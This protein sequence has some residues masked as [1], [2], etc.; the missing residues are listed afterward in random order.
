M[1]MWDYDERNVKITMYRFSVDITVAIH[2]IRN[3]PRAIMIG[4]PLTTCC[5]V[6]VNVAYLA[7]LSPAEMMA[8]EAVAVVSACP[9]RMQFVVRF[10]FAIGT[11]PIT[12]ASGL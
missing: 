3:L 7:V 6:L 5:Y 2:V 4:I 9:V 11:D 12:I 10:E 1:L 8:S